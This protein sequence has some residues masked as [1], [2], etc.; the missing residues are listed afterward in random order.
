M[1]GDVTPGEIEAVTVAE[2]IDDKLLPTAAAAFEHDADE[3]FLSPLALIL[4][5]EDDRR[6]VRRDQ[7]DPNQ[8]GR[9][10]LAR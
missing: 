4:E 3:P 7:I 6:A 1:D 5:V 2:V 10:P 9:P 8:S